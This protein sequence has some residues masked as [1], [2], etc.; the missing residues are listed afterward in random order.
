M[1]FQLTAE[2]PTLSLH[3]P[4]KVCRVTARGDSNPAVLNSYRMQVQ[5]LKM[6]FLNGEQ[7]QEGN[8][9]DIYAILLFEKSAMAL[10]WLISVI[11]LWG[12]AF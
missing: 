5:P 1:K 8:A 11:L 12:S 10:N 2:G 7:K 3:V 6:P 9:Y 4:F